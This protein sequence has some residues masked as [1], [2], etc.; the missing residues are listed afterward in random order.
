MFLGI[1]AGMA[2]SRARPRSVDPVL[3]LHATVL[4]ETADIARAAATARTTSF[5]MNRER[6]L[7][8][9]RECAHAPTCEPWL[10]DAIV[11]GAPRE[12]QQRALLVSFAAVSEEIAR[13]ATDDERATAAASAIRRTIARP[14]MGMAMLGEMPATTPA[15]A[16]RSPELARGRTLK[17]T[18]RI[19]EIRSRDGVAEGTLAT[20]AKTIV[21]FSTEMGTKGLRAGSPVTFFGVFLRRSAASD[22][23]GPSPPPSLVVV[24][25]FDTP[26][27][28]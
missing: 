16:S 15:S 3:S 20:E 21:E 14:G 12:D 17:V 23:T 13:A 25:A 11:D 26:E 6:R 19:L 7:Q 8:W 1:R 18:G 24:G 2:A 4:A 22:A 27:N 28:R 5:A 10:V 9:L